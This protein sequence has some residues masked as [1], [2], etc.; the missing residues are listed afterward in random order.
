MFAI[1][2]DDLSAWTDVNE[3]KTLY[4]SFL[5]EGGKVS[6]AVVPNAFEAFYRE[7][8]SLMYQGRERLKISENKE[9]VNYLMPYIQ[10]KQVE[11][12]QHGYD[13]GY[14]IETS[15]N[16]VF[17]DRE[18]RKEIGN[19]KLVKFIPECCAK[20]SATLTKNILEGRKILEDTFETKIKIFVPPSNGLIAEAAEIVNRMGMNISGTITNKFNR[21]M[22]KYSLLIILKKICWKIKYPEMSYPKIMK[23]SNH[24]ELT[25]HAYTPTT[26]MENFYKQIT[27]CKENGYSFVLATHYWE[28]LQNKKLR[29]DF[30]KLIYS[31]LKKS[32]IITVTEAF[33]RKEYGNTGEA[34]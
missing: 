16:K 33:G 19:T 13:H 26:N 14:Y 1:R 20:D 2:D 6:F 34:R 9:L 3:I 7:D 28:L 30:N 24:L 29:D 4:D 32:D 21:K 27:F 22:D 17:L 31:R 18:I 11:I 15:K 10:N 5:K 23:Y 12:M 8:R 25:G